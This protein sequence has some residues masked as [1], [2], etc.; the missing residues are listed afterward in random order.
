MRK[1]FFSSALTFLLVLTF[2]IVESSN[3]LSENERGWKAGVARVVITPQ[4]SM[5]LAGY[6]AR[7]DPSD[8]K[9]H[10]LWAKAL[11]LEDA[12]GKQTVLI[13]TDLLGLP[14][15]MSDKIRDRLKEK[16][17][18][19]RSQII[20]NSSHTHSGPVLQ[21]ALFDIYPL[22]SIQLKRI[23]RY[24]DWL[25]DQI[26]ALTGEAMQ[27]MKPAQLYTQNGVTRFQVNRRNNNAKTLIQQTELKGPN[28]Y[29]VP[30]IKVVNEAGDLM[31]VAFG[32]ACH[33]TVL[34]INKWS[35]D[36]PGFAQ[37]EL[38]KSHPDVTALF[39]QGAGSDQNPLPR[40]TIGLAK[41]YGKELAA[42]VERVLDEP[43]RELSPKL[44]TAYSEV[45]LS[46]ETPSQEELAQ[47]AETFTGYEK[48]WA[49]RMHDK[50]E[51]GE[52]LI[53]SYPYPVQIWQLGDQLILSMGGEVVID[54]SIGFKRIF[55]PD[56]FVMGYSN[57]V[58]SY[59]QTSKIIQEGGYES[60]SS[61]RVYGLPGKWKLDIEQL[62]YGEMLE[63][64]AQLGI[65]LPEKIMHEMAIKNYLSSS[66][67]SKNKTLTAKRYFSGFDDAHDTYNAISEAS[68]GK[69]Y[70][71]LSSALIDKGGQMYVYD[72]ETDETKFLADL[73]DVSGEKGHG[74]IAQGKSH[75][76]FH[77]KDGILYFATHVGYYEIIDGS[78]RLPVNPPDGYKLYP[79]GHF[80]SYDLSS[81]EFDELAI[82]PDGEG[83]ITMTMDKDRGHI[84]GITWP[85][86]YFIHYDMNTKKL[87]NLG[88]V[89]AM[90]E[91]GTPG[92][93][94]RVVCRSMFV[95]HRDGAVYYSTSEGDIFSYSPNSEAVKKVENVNL[96]LDYFGKYDPTDPG[97]MG[98]N[99]RQIIWHPEEGAAYGVHGN[100]GYLFRFDPRESDIEIVDR[101]TSE[102]SRR[103]GMFDYF[104][105][106]YLGFQLGTDGQTIY[107]LTGGPV[108]FEGHRAKGKEDMAMGGA[109]GLE[110]L[111]LVTYNIPNRKYMDHGPIFYPDG[112]R[113]I[114]VNSIA[115]GPN[116]NVYTLARFEHNGKIIE[117]LV[118]IPNPFSKK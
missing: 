39:F 24:S 53:S 82:A 54:Y 30:V 90:G 74:A 29:A 99:W 91:A 85:K 113:P 109:R 95:D 21:D 63:L 78:E 52:T 105:Y 79:G 17:E 43:M 13:T 47:M 76:R 66:Q 73:T 18:L 19:S 26:V 100:S 84:Y 35:G 5:W 92:D 93:D 28:D 67:D 112:E 68:D 104:T 116:G 2:Q 27:A 25:E 56:I 41:Q 57:D 36:Y 12:D 88:L 10:D 60:V 44:K 23:N 65:E 80:L 38:E 3:V 15:I 31:A 11:A 83:I 58:M 34:D 110:N 94:Y 96:R 97:S 6:A 102:P 51:R 98:Y 61:Q 7:T 72:P 101:I 37:L 106:G 86:G 48:R 71:V 81:G 59:I 70:Y 111:H 115:V 118:K 114:Y 89:S 87:K 9:L 108:Y 75:V 50:V 107:Y 45:E 1:L 46:L 22:D 62:I 4:Q 69:I 42:A 14:K 55:G 103:S 32:Y 8:G 16:F 33:P 49:I 77:E 40:R 117:D 64:S 20:L